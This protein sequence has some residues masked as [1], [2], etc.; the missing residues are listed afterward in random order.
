MLSNINKKNMGDFIDSS[1]EHLSKIKMYINKFDYI[2]QDESLYKEE[3]KALNLNAHL[4]YLFKSKKYQKAFL[5][6]NNIKEKMNK[7]LVNLINK[8]NF[9]KNNFIKQ[10]NNN[11]KTNNKKRCLFVNNENMLIING[12]KFD[13]KYLENK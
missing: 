7:E 4:F 3:L 2:V 11:N 12:I 8:K 9:K 13:N 10:E 5:I 1:I 6:V